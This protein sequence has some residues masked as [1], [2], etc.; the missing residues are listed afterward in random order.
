[1]HLSSPV[2]SECRASCWNPPSPWEPFKTPH[3]GSG[4]LEL[5]EGCPQEQL[6]S[7]LADSA[8]RE[9]EAASSS[10]K[11]G[12]SAKPVL[13]QCT[14]ELGDLRR[15]DLKRL[16]ATESSPTP[17]VPRVTQCRNASLSHHSQG[18]CGSRVACHSS[19]ARRDGRLLMVYPQSGVTQVGLLDAWELDAGP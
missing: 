12:N 8:E 13:W 10:L 9:L 17:W 14:V 19:H 6:A 11:D 1:V 4:Q 2:S 16:N 18:G 7:A 15:T 3:P 5:V